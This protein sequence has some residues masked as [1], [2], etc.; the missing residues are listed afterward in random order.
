[1]RAASILQQ[2]FESDLRDIHLARIRL[3][4]AAVFA[5]VRSGKLSLTNLGRAI[6][7]CTSHKHGIKRIDRLLGNEKLHSEKSIFYQAIAK[8]VIPSGS[9]PVI[10]VDWTAVTPIFWA[11]AAAVC[12]DGRALIIYGETHPISRY[13]KPQ[14]NA[15]FL[16]GLHRILPKDCQPIIIADAGFRAPFMKLVRKHGWDYVV[17]LRGQNALIRMEY[18]CGW[19]K[20]ASLFNRIGM[21]P[22][23]FGPIEI[24]KRVRYVSRLVGIRK[25]VTHAKRSRV[26]RGT[27]TAR[28]QQAA[29]EP[30]TLATSLDLSPSK[31]IAIYSRRMQIEETFRDAKCSR[32]GLCLSQARTTSENRADVLL[33]LA[34]LAHLFA[35]LVGVVAESAQLHLRFQANTVRKRV[36]SLATLGR[37]VVASSEFGLLAAKISTTA[38]RVLRDRMESLTEFQK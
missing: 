21:K 35:V 34:S 9:R 3:V 23:D 15:T 17:R 30:W 19:M 11:L 18:G 12:F 20:V 27:T 16:R 8:R 1:M 14:V 6:A 5:L 37:F 4:F 25:P 38:W 10:V 36:F 33:L 7:E 28:M 29:S 2:E 22:I 32:F 24:G 26:R 13:L 31:V